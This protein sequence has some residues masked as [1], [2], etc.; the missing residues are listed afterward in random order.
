M[1]GPD[2]H[3]ALATWLENKER[4]G[5]GEG[6]VLVKVPVP[7]YSPLKLRDLADVLNHTSPLKSQN[8]DQGP[9]VAS[10]V[11]PCISLAYTL[12][13]PHSTSSTL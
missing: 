13:T 10:L 8:V 1:I 6:E 12:F 2:R 11:S 4:E 3:L 5:G 9:L 7:G